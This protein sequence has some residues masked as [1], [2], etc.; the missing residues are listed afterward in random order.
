MDPELGG[1]VL[2]IGSEQSVTV[3][4]GRG[5]RFSEL[6]TEIRG[7]D[8]DIQTFLNV[9]VSGHFLIHTQETNFHPPEKTLKRI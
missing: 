3:D 7:E 2:A 6:R 1:E 8:A 4:P 9:P 5:W